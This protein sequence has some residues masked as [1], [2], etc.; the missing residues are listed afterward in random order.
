M[1]MPH[2]TNCPHSGDGWCLACVG[3]LYEKLSCLEDR[4]YI[5]TFPRTP[6]LY[7]WRE[8]DTSEWQTLMVIGDTYNNPIFAHCHSGE[9]IKF[10]KTCDFHR[11]GMDYWRNDPDIPNGEWRPFPKTV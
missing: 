2:L 9:P 4:A 5:S 1:T 10:K 7:Q 11:L 8:D 3:E 6:G